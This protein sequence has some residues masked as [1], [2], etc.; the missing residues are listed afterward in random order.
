MPSPQVE[1]AMR[2][3]AASIRSTV[4]A[5]FAT[6]AAPFST[7]SVNLDPSRRHF[8]EHV[9]PARVM[10]PLQAALEK[11]EP[12]SI[13][14]GS[15]RGIEPIVSFADHGAP[16]FAPNGSRIFAHGEVAAVGQHAG[17]TGSRPGGRGVARGRLGGWRRRIDHYRRDTRRRLIDHDVVVHVG[18]HVT[19]D[20]AHRDRAGAA[21]ATAVRRRRG[22]RGIVWRLRLG[23]R[24]QRWQMRLQAGRE[25]DARRQRLR[26]RRQRWQMRLQAGR[27]WMPGGSGF[28]IGGSVGECGC[29]PGGCW[30]PGGSG[31]AVEESCRTGPCV[32]T[33][34]ARREPKPPPPEKLWATPP[35][36]KTWPPPPIWPPPKPPPP[37][38]RADA[39]V[40]IT[41]V[42]PRAATAASPRTVLRAACS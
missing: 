26:D 11:H 30:M 34:R 31:L 2:S 21:S 27:R 1:P 28:A 3:R 8:G 24:R 13:G 29:R 14:R 41:R 5:R 19:T 38:P 22:W 9:D 25:V 36:P 18:N 4:C 17:S 37:K 33:G 35:P 42:P 32:A 6:R 16:Q 23:D 39:S 7:R 15:D 12:G 40:A 10:L 20:H